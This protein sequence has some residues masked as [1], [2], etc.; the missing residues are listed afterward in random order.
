MIIIVPIVIIAGILVWTLR[1]KKETIRTRRV[2]ILATAIPSVIL[3]IATLISQLLHNSAGGDEVSNVS[4][5]L[6]IVSIGLIGLG[7][8]V[9]L[10]FFAIRKMEIVKGIGFG[11]SVV[12]II[13]IIELVLLESFAG[14]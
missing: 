8:L 14:V 11:L 7:I 2:P 13:A 1:P 6:F 10:G 5:I 9:L 3:A 4:D 12:V